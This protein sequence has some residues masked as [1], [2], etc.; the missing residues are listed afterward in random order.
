[1]AVAPASGATGNL[2]DVELSS[3]RVLNDGSVALAMCNP[4][5]T[6]I[7]SILNSS[8][9]STSA[10]A[11][12]VGPNGA[13]NPTL[14]VDGSVTSEATGLNVVGA[15]AGSRVALNVLSSGTNEGL[16][17]NPKA[18]ANILLSSLS[19]NTGVQVGANA[20]VTTTI[21]TVKSSNANALAVGPNSTTNPSFSVDASTTSAATGLNVKSAAAAAGLALSVT[22]SGTNE[23]LTVDAKGSGTV[24]I[25]G[26]STGFVSLGRGGTSST[27]TSSTV[28]SLGTTQNS[29]PTAAQ[30]LGG[31]VTQTGSTGAGTVTLPTGTQLSTA[32]PGV[33]VGD[34]FETVFANL[35][36]GQTLT[37]TGATGST[38]VGTAA[39]GSGKNA[40]LIFVN[41]GSNTWN[42]YVRVSA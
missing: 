4:D 26:T 17:I 22:S 11:F 19:G 41:T 32:V 1:M 8:I 25:G 38:V 15:A 13:T 40:S 3:Y 28:A 20:S 27:I 35:G 36:G 18:S 34:T 12:V 10:N 16:Q 39:I 7:N 2:S 30:L 33:A 29:T 9:T 42:V 14:N 31:V 21:F 6:S 23:N 37:I 5:G 24:T